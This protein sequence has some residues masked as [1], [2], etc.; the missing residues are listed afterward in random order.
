MTNVSMKPATTTNVGAQPISAEV[1]NAHQAIERYLGATL[2]DT[3]GGA[4]AADSG[5]VPSTDMVGAP[6]DMACP[7]CPA[8]LRAAMAYTLLAPSKRAR[9]VL[10]IIV[11]DALSGQRVAV[12]PPAAALEMLHAASLILDDL[13]AMDDAQ[14]RRGQPANHLCHGEDTA[15]LASVGLINVAYRLVNGSAQ[16]PAEARS[17][18]SLI[19][20]DTVGP[21]GL[22]G[23]QYDDLKPAAPADGDQ[24]EVA[25]IEHVHL[26]KTARLFSAACEIGALS[27]GRDDLV[28]PLGVFGEAIGLAFQAYDDLLD[29]AGDAAALGK[30]VGQDQETL[31][32]VGA[33]GLDAATKRADAHMQRGIEALSPFP[34]D[35]REPLSAYAAHILTGMK[36]KAAA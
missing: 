14:M 32:V 27:A 11:S 9:A 23:G 15:I 34:E 3:R 24:G 19:L 16:L 29:A 8:P 7:A 5:L 21:C 18:I 13:P 22:T 17:R 25:R 31:T 10:A 1:A 35:V 28:A 30:D 20:A 6:I 33:V 2:C 26:R 4:V 12:L 36:L